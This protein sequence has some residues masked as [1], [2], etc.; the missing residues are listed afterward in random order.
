M[1][2]VVNLRLKRKQAARDEARRKGDENAVKHG[3]SK[4]VRSLDQARADK[5]AREL[6]GHKREPE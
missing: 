6:D 3:L 5:A 4:A 1:G 2:D